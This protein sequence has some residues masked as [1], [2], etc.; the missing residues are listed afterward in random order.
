MNYEVKKGENSSLLI[1]LNFEEKEVEDKKKEKLQSYS[2]TAEAPGF[3]KGKVPMD[4]VEKQYAGKVMQDVSEEL[5]NDNYPNIVKDEKIVPV[6]APLI[7]NIVEKD[8]LNLEIKVEIFPE[9]KLGQYKGLEV[10][11]PEVEIKEEDVIKEL[12]VEKEKN[13]KLKEVEEGEEA[14][15]EDTVIMDF[16]GFVDG[17]AFEGGK[18]DNY[19]LK[20][21]SGQFIP[22][23]EEQLVGHK[24]GEEFDVKVTFPEEYP[25][26]DLAG[27]EA[28]FKIKLHAI[29]RVENNELNDE[30]A[31]DLGYE[32]LE[33]M[34]Q[35]KQTELEEKEKK[36][37]EQGFLNAILEK[38]KTGSELEIPQTFIQKETEYRIKE[39]ENQLMRQGLTLDVYLKQTKSNMDDIKEQLKPIAEEKVKMDI[40]INEIS[41]L[42]EIEVK[43]EEIEEKLAEV[44]KYYSMEIEELKK[45][46]KEKGNY[47]NFIESLKMEKIS[48]KTIDLILNE[49]IEK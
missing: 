40:I 48:E 17:V 43:E 22:G 30:L 8:G 44:A 3:R 18:A 16:E 42:E 45:E 21:G 7:N 4:I 1:N 9:V 5:I 26:D 2:K 11:K 29:K 49:T 28:I 46:L 6:S 36:E 34:K 19:E 37:V 35:S 31:K 27:Q 38:I 12:E 25:K 33:D 13:A 23:F 39:M 47:T 15:T 24:A 10:E 20:L 14:K 32:D 41:K